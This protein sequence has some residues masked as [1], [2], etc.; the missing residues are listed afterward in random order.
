MPEWM[1]VVVGLTILVIMVSLSMS[2]FVTIIAL[3]KAI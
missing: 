1:K 3:A 2:L